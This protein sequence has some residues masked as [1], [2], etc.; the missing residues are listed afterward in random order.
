MQ[1]ITKVLLLIFLISLSTC[2]DDTTTTDDT[3]DV[4]DN[5]ENAD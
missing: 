1:K 4:S 5:T 3:T 2:Q